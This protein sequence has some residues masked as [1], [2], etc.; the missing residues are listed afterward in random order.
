VTLPVVIGIF[1]FRAVTRK[2]RVVMEWK[3][4]LAK[5]RRLTQG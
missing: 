1:V 4:G 2:Y 5:A 3:N